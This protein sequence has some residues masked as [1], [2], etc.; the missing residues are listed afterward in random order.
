MN[1]ENVVYIYIDIYIYS[2]EDRMSLKSW[3]ANM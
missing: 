2:R 1:K 3:T